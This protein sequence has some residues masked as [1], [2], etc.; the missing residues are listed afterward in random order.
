MTGRDPVARLRADI[1]SADADVLVTRIPEGR[2]A[3]VE[4]IEALSEGPCRVALEAWLAATDDQAAP[5]LRS[6]AFAYGR[7]A[8]AALN[9][10]R[11]PAAVPAVQPPPPV[12][13]LRQDGKS[14]RPQNARRSRKEERDFFAAE[15]ARQMPLPLGDLP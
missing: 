7:L 11:L 14:R 6:L 9:A 15:L 1:D 2:R 5:S 12:P 8:L 10:Y 4:A 13:A 3:A